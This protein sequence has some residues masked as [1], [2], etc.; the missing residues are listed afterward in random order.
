MKLTQKYGNFIAFEDLKEKLDQE[1]LESKHQRQVPGS[2][3]NRRLDS[4]ECFRVELDRNE[5]YQKDNCWAR[6]HDVN[7]LCSKH[8][9]FS[10]VFKSDREHTQNFGQ[11]IKWQSSWVNIFHVI[12]SSK[13]QAMNETARISMNLKR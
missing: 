5:S 2:L 11:P 1:Q 3:E 12:S 6:K 7:P 13:E 8:N 9:P 4:D 10:M